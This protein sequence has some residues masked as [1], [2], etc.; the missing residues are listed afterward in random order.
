[1]SILVRQEK[2]EDAEAISEVVRRGAYEHVPFSNHR[3]HLMVSR[4][5][6]S[7]AYVPQLSLLAEIAGEI[8]GHLLLT[9]IAIRDGAGSTPSLALAPL[10][11]TPASQRRGV[12]GALIGEAHKRAGELGFLSVVVVGIEGYYQKFGYVPLSLYP[13]RVP[14]EVRP[15]NCAIVALCTDG[16]AGLSGVIEYAPEWME[17]PCL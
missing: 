10:S 5:R 16:L 11:V 6:S 2:P 14:F 4:L 7:Q 13:I 3:E 17:A 15:E 9:R 12:G 8:V 1:M